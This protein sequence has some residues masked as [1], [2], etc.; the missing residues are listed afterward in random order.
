VA[1]LDA[2][3]LP[4]G[5]ADALAVEMDRV[6]DGTSLDDSEGDDETRDH[7]GRRTRSSGDPSG[8][9]GEL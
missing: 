7:E 8:R 5:S 6:G 3:D 9:P 2:S 1:D 4:V